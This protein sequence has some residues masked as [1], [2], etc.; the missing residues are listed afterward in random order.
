MAAIMVATMAAT[1]AAEMAE[2]DEGRLARWSRLKAKGGASN[3]ENAAAVRVEELPTEEPDEDDR[4]MTGLADPASLP[5]GVQNRSF[6]PP[7]PPLASLDE[8]AGDETAYEAPPPEALA[9]LQG[10]V[11]HDASPDA[12]P[13]AV[14]DGLTDALDVEERPLTVEEEAAVS[15]LP[16]LESLTKESDFTPFLADNIPEFIRNRALKILWR[17]NPLFGFQDGLDDYAENYRV[18]DKLITAATDSIY[19]PGKG[20]AVMEE[21]EIDDEADDEPDDEVGDG[22]EE[23]GGDPRSDQAPDVVD[24]PPEV[25]EEVIVADANETAPAT[26]E[27]A[28]ADAPDEQ[29]AASANGRP[30]SDKNG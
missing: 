2:R 1:M 28:P 6:V 16:P 24:D 5:G 12:I 10:D 23:T 17:S 27:A 25:A 15:E 18:I 9:M 19:R 14:P 13:D 3:D 8:T 29:P 21:D 11:A 26:N 22:R 30:R 7:M 4:G 20:Y